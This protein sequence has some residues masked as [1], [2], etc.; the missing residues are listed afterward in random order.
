MEKPIKYYTT[1]ICYQE[2]PD[3]VSFGYF[4]T[5]CPN[6]CKNCHSPH[7]RDDIG[8]V[9]LNDLENHLATKA[10]Y[11]SCI[12][13]MGGDD[14]N[15]ID[16]LIENIKVCKEK[17]FR[18]ALYSGFNLEHA[19]KDLLDILDYI[20]VGPYIEEMGPLKNKNTNQRL[21]KIENGSI[22]EDITYRFW[23]DIDEY[24]T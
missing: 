13:F 10:K 16:S 6:K 1:K 11:C 5:G 4:L 20:K 17:G 12:L 15:H 24:Y 23:R 2:V 22:K 3:E 18:T 21:Y 14:D 8:D 19:R 7:L 9:V